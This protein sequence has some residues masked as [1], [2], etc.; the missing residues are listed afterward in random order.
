MNSRKALSAAALFFVSMAGGA[1]SL[2]SHADVV[3]HPGE[4]IFVNTPQQVSC[5]GGAGYQPTNVSVCDCMPG[6]SF[7]SFGQAVGING[8]DLISQCQAI[9][10]AANPFNCKQFTLQPGAQLACDCKPGLHF[11]SFGQAIGRDG[12]DLLKQ[13]NAI[14]PAT[15]PFSCGVR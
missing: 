11:N 13:C 2:V 14:N 3:I 4:S 15:K 5:G 1:I 10:P 6:P 7:D 9:N 12:A 8:N